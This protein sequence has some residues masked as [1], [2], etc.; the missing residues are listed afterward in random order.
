MYWSGGTRQAFE[1]ADGE[2]EGGGWV[3]GRLRDPESKGDD[4]VESHQHWG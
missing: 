2:R 4:E 1:G 3:D